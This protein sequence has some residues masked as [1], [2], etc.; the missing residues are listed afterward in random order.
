MK[1]VAQSVG[2]GE[3]EV[4]EVPEPL[5]DDH[6]ALVQ[7]RASLVSP[8]TER[9]K[10]VTGN[11]SLLGKARARPDQVAAVIEKAKQDGLRQT[12]QA[13]RTRLSAPT[14][15]GYSS[16]G[17]VLAVGARVP[18]IKPGDRVACGGA[19]YAVHAEINRVPGNLC[20]AL[21]AA[22]SFDEGAFATVGSI[23]LH[24]VRQAQPTIGERAAVIGLGLV[25]QLAGQILR[26]NGC[27][28]V[29]IDLDASVLEQAKSSGAAD[30]V[31]ERGALDPARLAPEASGC[32]FVLLTAA[33][34]SD[35]PV[36]LAAALCRDRGRVVVV[37]DVGLGVPRAPY[38]EKEIDL[39]LSRSYGPGRYDVNY[40]ERGLDYPIGYVR[41]TERRNMAA[42]L[43]L[44]AARRIEVSPLIRRRVPI[45]Q[46]PT[47]FAEL[48]SDQ[49]SP[50]GLVLTYDARPAHDAPP[51]EVVSPAYDAAPADVAS[52]AA[53]NGRAPDLAW[54]SPPPP[55]R[56]LGE[57]APRAVMIGAGS[58]AQRIVLPGL[59]AAG[60][61]LQGIAS[62]SGLSASGAASMHDAERADGVEALL[63]Q[64]ADL[65]AIAARHCSHE[66]LVRAALEHGRT[67][68]V[69]K[70]PC[71][72]W[73]GLA[74]LRA[75][76]TAAGRDLFVGF[77]RRHAPLVGQM[78]Q[79][80][81][82]TGG[83]REILIRVAAGRL[84]E[85]HWLNDVDDGGGRLLGEG[86]HFVDL[87]CYLAGA[88]PDR[89]L[90]SAAPE[91]DRPLQAAQR[92]AVTLTFADGSIA[93]IN[94]GDTAASGV[95]KETVELHGGG[96]SAV[97]ED[98]KKL[99]VVRGRSRQSPRARAQDKGHQR[100]FEAMRRHLAGATGNGKPDASGATLLLPDPLDTMAATL[101]ALEA[102]RL[103]TSLSPRDF[104]A[105]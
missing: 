67:T 83:P 35:D 103:G 12:I 57:R 8:G 24:G 54:S 73:Q 69:E 101:T 45:E 64:D 61:E 74:A 66:A 87:A 84:P 22:V 6:E 20:A 98:F 65:V 46:A 82:A 53:A 77:N 75:A 47:V 41:W 14:S 76:R 18:D 95:P 13:V 11:K 39:R 92:F 99:T 49:T 33:T 52:P 32:D 93:T 104:L 16:A 51:A 88:L 71:L 96:V 59:K 40:E 7:V 3:I 80:V 100:Q 37:G 15:L 90:C 27:R 91:P 30:V 38:Y 21:P 9:T 60:F 1:Q 19:G 4:R 31:F 44:I 62:A 105:G 56:P 86:C 43:D 10:V 50:L 72:D 102:A 36:A 28:V 17:I 85:D 25:G 68:Y 55:R 63:A 78:L 70:P 79:A 29:G 97:I 81:P 48:G 94:Y 89:V 2:S 42:F 23:A 5:I 58:F 34:P 26:A